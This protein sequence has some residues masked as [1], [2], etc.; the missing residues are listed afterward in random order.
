VYLDEWTK[1]PFGVV[2]ALRRSVYVSVSVSL[3][4]LYSSHDIEGGTTFMC[5]YQKN[6]N[7][8]VISLF[9]IKR[10]KGG[11]WKKKTNEKSDQQNPRQS[12]SFTCAAGKMHE[13]HL[14]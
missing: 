10:K 8:C 1:E 7:A 6:T 3:C 11:G 4:L 5:I 14:Q 13:S 9:L 2:S 12:N